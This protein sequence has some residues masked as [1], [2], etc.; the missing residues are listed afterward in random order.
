KRIV[1]ALFI[2]VTVDVCGWIVTPGMFRFFKSPGF[3]AKQMFAWGFFSKIFINIALSIKIF[4]YYGTSSE[5]RSAINTFI[6]R[7]KLNATT[8]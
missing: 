6:L 8:R 1:K 5:Y 3:N 4:I 7:R 2:I